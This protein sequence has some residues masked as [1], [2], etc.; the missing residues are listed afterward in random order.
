MVRRFDY[1]AGEGRNGGSGWG[2]KKRVGDN[3]LF[4]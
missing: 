2:A 4:V 1:L 3:V